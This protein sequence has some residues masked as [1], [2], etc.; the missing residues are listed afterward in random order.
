[1]LLEAG[2]YIGCFIFNINSVRLKYGF[3]VLFF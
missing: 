3:Q 1:M 2:E